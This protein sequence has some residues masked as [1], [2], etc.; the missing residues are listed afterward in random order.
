MVPSTGRSSERYT[1]PAA[2]VNASTVPVRI[3]VVDNASTDGSGDHVRTSHPDVDLVEAGRNAGYAGG[4][5][6]GLRRTA[7]RYAF[8][9]NPDVIIEPDH[10]AILR[11]RLDADSTIGAA[12]EGAK[13]AS[14]ICIE[15]QLAAADAIRPGVTADSVYQ[16][17]KRCIDKAGLDHYHRHHCGYLVGI[18]FPPSWSGSGVPRG[19][20]Q[21]VTLGFQLLIAAADASPG[22]WRR[23]NRG[24]RAGNGREN[25]CDAGDCGNGGF[26]GANDWVGGWRAR[27]QP[28]AA[29]RN[30][31]ELDLLDG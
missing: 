29:G 7:G 18:G 15:A 1:C 5:N 23:E 28:K 30:A 26:P 10:L 13:R 14:E 11:Q 8:V 21:L 6:I 22:F 12:Q 4:A 27:Y 2:A 19:L 17:W 20:R 25:T 31:A 24:A 3:V 16:A 9:M